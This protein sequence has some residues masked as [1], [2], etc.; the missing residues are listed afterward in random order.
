MF[1]LSCDGGMNLKYINKNRYIWKNVL[2]YSLIY[3]VVFI[4]LVWFLYGISINTVVS[5]TKDSERQLLY[6]IRENISSTINLVDNL[7]DE[8][9]NDKDLCE[10]LIRPYNETGE[11]IIYYIEDI[12]PRLF[13]RKLLFPQ[14]YSLY[15]F[16]AN[17][18][19]P[20]SYNNYVGI[21]NKDRYPL[22]WE[23]QPSLW[24]EKH[25]Y[26]IT[27]I[28]SK[29]Q[30]Y[31]SCNRVIASPRNGNMIA[32]LNIQI[33]EDELFH[34]LNEYSTDVSEFC[35][36]GGD[37]TVWYS[38]VSENN[39]SNLFSTYSLIPEDEL[40]S[41][42]GA[43]YVVDDSIILVLPLPEIEGYLVSL[44]SLQSVKDEIWSRAFPL[45]LIM[46]FL[47]AVVVCIVIIV[48]FFNNKR[49]RN[50][51]EAMNY[52][53]QGDYNVSVEVGADDE[54]GQIN[55]TFNQMVKQIDEMFHNVYQAEIRQRDAQIVALEAQV[56][57]HFLYNM[58]TSI[59]CSAQQHGDLS[60]Q[61][62]AILLSKFY[63]ASLSEKADYISILEELNYLN[64]YVDIQLI[65]F[66]QNLQYTCT[67]QE[68]LPNCKIIK[69]LLQ[70]LVEN[71]IVHGIEN[72]VGERVGTISVDI[73]RFG[74]KLV[75]DV[76]DNGL[77]MPQEYINQINSG[78]FYASHASRY[79]LKNLLERL[80]LFYGDQAGLTVANKPD[81]GAQ[82][83]LWLPLIESE[84]P[85][86]IEG[87]D[88]N[89]SSIDR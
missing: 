43:D 84:E 42:T 56:N 25:P 19:I 88:A 31:F 55:R 5:N 83:T 50:L 32:L 78:S 29:R 41:V 48:T 36:I 23:G 1:V 30:N 82:I 87:G 18:Q 60:T 76:T 46:I 26:D 53:N 49:I 57:P 15:V 75:V 51:V 52:V 37:G 47:Y 81:S 20:P 27:G 74:D 24:W 64:T 86:C 85:L 77:G 58:L 13:S 39:E 8:I 68:G 35:V 4:F 7:A 22:E 73:K 11:E 80:S 71:A 6:Q 12:F 63:R 65:R 9:A 28:S 21:L 44:R 89:V 2:L 33:T 34:C 66:G 45:I 16:S 69:N 67:L 10:F 79:G 14:L 17:E 70:P 3:C 72:I 38:S 59:A 54:L 40:N 61:R 62:M